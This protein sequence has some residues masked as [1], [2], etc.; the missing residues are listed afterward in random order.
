L[1]ENSKDFKVTWKL[2]EKINRKLH[3]NR[4]LA[5][6]I[7]RGL[8]EGKVKPILVDTVMGNK[9]TFLLGIEDI[10]SSAA[11][12]HTK[13]GYHCSVSLPDDYIIPD[14]VLQWM[15]EYQKQGIK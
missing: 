8:F 4:A 15:K 1:H 5:M 11:P 10:K 3:E 2:K 12:F 13:S 6:A 14:K 9:N 7:G